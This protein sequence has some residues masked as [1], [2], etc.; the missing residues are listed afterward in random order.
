LNKLLGVAGNQFDGGV[1]KYSLTLGDVFDQKSSTTFND[2]RTT[3]DTSASEVPGTRPTTPPPTRDLFSEI[4]LN[5]HPELVDNAELYLNLPWR[6]LPGLTLRQQTEKEEK[7]EALT[8]GR[9]DDTF[10]WRYRHQEAYGNADGLGE[11]YSTPLYRRPVQDILLREGHRSNDRPSHRGRRLSGRLDN[12]N[13]NVALE[14]K[15]DDASICYPPYNPM[16]DTS[17]HSHDESLASFVL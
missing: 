5:C 11:K 2:S 15:D 16:F 9:L 7:T 1:S 4:G 12:T 14:E 3:Y 10:H 17:I 8:K 13:E 6:R